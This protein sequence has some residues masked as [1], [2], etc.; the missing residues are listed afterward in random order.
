MRLQ[1]A[2]PSKFFAHVQ[3]PSRDKHTRANGASDRLHVGR[4]LLNV[5][6]EKPF[7]HLQG[8]STIGSVDC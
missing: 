1:Q 7:G 3:Q 4:G 2:N 8:R 6:R 5:A